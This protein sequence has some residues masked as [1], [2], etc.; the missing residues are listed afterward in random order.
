MPSH[1]VKVE[2]IVEAKNEEKAFARVADGV[3]RSS[4]L[5]QFPFSGSNEAIQTLEESAEDP[6]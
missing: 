1:I 6:E 4:I 2:F 5:S 3:G